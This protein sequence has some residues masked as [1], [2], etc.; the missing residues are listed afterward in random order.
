MQI[1]YN[2]QL[3][4]FEDHIPYLRPKNLKANI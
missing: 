3:E 1:P 4:S 2:Y